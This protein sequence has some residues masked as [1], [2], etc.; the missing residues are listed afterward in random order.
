MTN[1]TK[2]YH[3]LKSKMEILTMKTS[4]MMKLFR[5]LFMKFLI[6]IYKEMPPREAYFSNFV[7]CPP[8]LK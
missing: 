3:H 5:Q 8:K 7:I 6:I 4:Q 2:I 1:F